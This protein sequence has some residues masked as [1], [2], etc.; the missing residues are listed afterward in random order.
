MDILFKITNA[1]PSTPAIVGD[2]DFMAHYSGIHK[3]MAWAEITPGI[4][5]ATEKYVLP[6]IGSDLY[7]DLAAKYIAGGSLTT[8]QER[9]IEILQDCIAYYTAY[10]IMPERTA[11]FSSMG[12]SQQTPT[13]GSGSP[14]NQWG[15]KQMRWS[16]LQNADTF[17]DSALAYL[18]KQV[19]ASVAYF[20]LWKDND[21]YTKAKSS[22]FR[23]TAQLDAYLNIQESRRSYISLIKYMKEVEEDEILPIL[24]QTQFDALL[25][26]SPT[27][28]QIALRAKVEK[29]VAWLGLRAAIPNHRIV[30]DGDGFRVVSQSD[31]FDDR[32][33]QDNSVAIM[34]LLARAEKNGARYLSD[35]RAFL[36][37]NADDYPDWLTSDCNTDPTSTGHSIRTSYNQEG[38]IGIF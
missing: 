21:A 2:S 17:L 9:I 27:A 4:R 34:S 38:G 20:D 6:F 19:A 32:K 10:H 30:I 5:Q 11:F 31:Q 7:D 1:T 14:V 22:F 24:C 26:V 23:S 36:Q 12:V 33:S 28:E 8:E 16:A 3:N 29:A 37:N 18:E 13:E 15:W 25:G 35:M